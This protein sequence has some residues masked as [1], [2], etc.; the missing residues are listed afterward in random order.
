MLGLFSLAVFSLVS[1]DVP[2]ESVEFPAGSIA[3]TFMLYSVS[4]SSPSS[5]ATPVVS[6]LT[7][8]SPQL[9]PAF[10]IQYEYVIS[11]ASAPNLVLFP[12]IVSVASTLTFILVDV[13]FVLSTALAAEV[14]N[15]GGFMSFLIFIV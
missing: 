6:P 2:F 8:A 5:T 9:A 15:V 4:G 10:A 11:P 14:E 3:T 13:V 1:I 12:D 7:F